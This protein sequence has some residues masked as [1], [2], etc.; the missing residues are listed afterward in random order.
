LGN[1]AIKVDDLN[2]FTGGRGLTTLGGS[3]RSGHSASG[4][5]ERGGRKR[6]VL[7]KSSTTKRHGLHLDLLLVPARKPILLLLFYQ[8]E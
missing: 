4:Q 8:W 1:V 3:G 5:G 6:G 2:R 7:E